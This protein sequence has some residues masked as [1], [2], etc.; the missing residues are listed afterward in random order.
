MV[1]E[2]NDVRKQSYL[3]SYGVTH[4]VYVGVVSS[5]QRTGGGSLHIVFLVGRALYEFDAEP[6]GKFVLCGTNNGQERARAQWQLL[7]GVKDRQSAMRPRRRSRQVCQG[8][9]VIH[10]LR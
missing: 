9:F 2:N 7:D 4:H 1:S 5:S 6:I 3:V 8:G 10:N